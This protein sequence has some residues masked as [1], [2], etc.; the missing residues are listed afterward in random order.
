MVFTLWS[1]P[2][3]GRTRQLA[4]AA[5]PLSDV[6]ASPAFAGPGAEARLHLSGHG[7]AAG[8]LFVRLAFAPAPKGAPPP[9][10][11]PQQPHM[12]PQQQYY[13][14]MG[15][16]PLGGHAQPFVHQQQQVVYLSPGQQAPPMT[17]GG[18]VMGVPVARPGQAGGGGA[19][20]VASVSPLAKQV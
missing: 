17:N 1:G 10:Q 4:S 13:A 5:L 15:Y 12:S 18:L 14:Q 19:T 6:A 8:T 9:P 11:Q 20:L 7:A 3:V 16:A 2:L